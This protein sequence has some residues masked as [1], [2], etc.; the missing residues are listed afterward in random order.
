M[1]SVEPIESISTERKI[2]ISIGLLSVIATLVSLGFAVY[3]FW[4]NKPGYFFIASSVCV[5]ACWIDVIV[6]G[7]LKATRKTNNKQELK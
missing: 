2:L 3:G 1:N 7:I 5:I 6:V 4:D